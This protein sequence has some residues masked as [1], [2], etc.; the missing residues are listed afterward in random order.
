VEISIL[1]RS[2]TYKSGKTT[3]MKILFW[4]RIDRSGTFGSWPERK[5]GQRVFDNQAPVI[6]KNLKKSLKLELLPSITHS[7]NSE[8]INPR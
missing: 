5:P 2:I 7:M 8:R 6:Y 1:L 4:R 3:K